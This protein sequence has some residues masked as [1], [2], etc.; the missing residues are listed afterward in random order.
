[1]SAAGGNATPTHGSHPGEVAM[2]IVLCAFMR[3]AGSGNV[4]FPM[5][6]I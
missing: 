6:L 3:M 1:M 4:E 2:M 5:H